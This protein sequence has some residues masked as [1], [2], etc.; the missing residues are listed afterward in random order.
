MSEEKAQKIE[1]NEK[2]YRGLGINDDAL[3]ASI[4]QAI[5][6]Y[7]GS[8]DKKQTDAGV[9][10]EKALGILSLSYVKLAQNFIRDEWREMSPE[11][12]LFLNFGVVDA[13][14]IQS[15]QTLDTL[16]NE[17]DS[18]TNHGGFEIYYL[19]EWFEK[20]GRGVIPLTSEMAQTKAKTATKEQEDRV[21]EKIHLIEKELEDLYKKEFEGFQGF[22]KLFGELKVDGD[23]SH[24]LK[25]LRDIRRTAADLENT[26][27]DQAAKAA[28]LDIQKGKIAKDDAELGGMIDSRRAEQIQR[29]RDELDIMVKVMRSGAVRGGLLKNTPVL[30]DKWIPLDTRLA[31]MTKDYVEARLSELEAIDHTIF[32]DKKGKRTPPK[33]LIVPGVGTG[34]A[35]RDRIITPLFA[36]PTISPDISLIRTLA[37]YRWFRATASFNW[38]DLPGE[39]GSCYAYTRPGVQFNTLQKNFTD[40][41]VDWMTREAQGYQ[42]L[43]AE[44][45]K[46]FWRMIPYPHDIKEKLFKRATVYRQLMSQDMAGK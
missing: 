11:R 7:L 31:I 32:L 37:G 35:W 46:V 27:K 12:K 19:N 8:H 18:R 34:M 33:I 16:V 42:V 9:N 15:A 14:L 10:F 26:I 41:Y 17:L 3:M 2:F 43:N 29:L 36:P 22:L 5:E 30:I 1:I 21:I 39:L 45:R 13:R 4:E 44:V 25:L 38:K 20:V 40:D 23:A 24:K 6:L 28:E